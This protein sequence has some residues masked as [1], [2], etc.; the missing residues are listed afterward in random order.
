MGLPFEQ[1]QRGRSLRDRPDGIRAE[2]HALPGQPVRPHPTE[3]D[4]HDQRRG[5]RGRDYA[6]VGDRARQI[7][8]DERQRDRH[9]PVAERRDR[10]TEEQQPKG[11]MTERS[12]THGPKRMRRPATAG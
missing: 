2:H 7:E 4:E 6:E 11:R 5:L 10:L 1:E 8:D 12:A 3:Q 9:Q